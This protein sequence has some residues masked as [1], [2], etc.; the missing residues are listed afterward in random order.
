MSEKWSEFEKKASRRGGNK[1]APTDQR[2]DATGV[3]GVE[4][5]Y[6]SESS[7]NLAPEAERLLRYSNLSATTSTADGRA[8]DEFK[9]KFQW[10]R[11]HPSLAFSADKQS[12]A[13]ATETTSSSDT[14]TVA[15]ED[16]ARESAKM[17][18]IYSNSQMRKALK[19]R[20]TG[21][22]IRKDDMVQED[23]KRQELSLEPPTLRIDL[24][25]L[26]EP[27]LMTTWLPG[28]DTNT[29]YEHDNK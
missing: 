21:E 25:E 26:I 27:P 15:A 20:K 23:L 10:I 3:R 24:A 2:N 14:A 4:A 18:E 11:P 19:R 6:V 1:K 12:E 7:K 5:L 13:T 8:D 9:L 28:Q 17:I 16:S 29:S 22:G